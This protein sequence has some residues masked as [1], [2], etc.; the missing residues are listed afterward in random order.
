[1]RLLVLSVTLALAATAALAGTPVSISGIYPGL[2][3]FN[4]NGECGVGAVVPWAGRLWWFTYPPH[5]RTGSDDGLYSTD[6]SMT[7]TRHPE[8][9]GGTH[10]A[11]L[12]HRE[13][14][15]LFLGPYAIDDRGRVRV[16]DVKAIPGRY[17]AWAR[18]LTD[19]ANKLLLFDMEGPVWEVDVR[20]LAGTKLFDK[21]VPGWHGKGAY[22]AQ[23]RYVVANNGESAA[24]RR[25]KDGEFLCK[26]P[27]KSAEDAGVLAEWDGREWRIVERRQFTE[28][29][30]PGGIEGSPDDTAPL[31]A[32]GWDRRSVIL[33]LLDGGAWST[34]RL[35]KGSHTFDPSHGWFTEW[36]R[37][38]SIGAAR[39]MMVMHGQMFDFPGGFRTGTTGGLRPIATHLRYIPDFCEWNGRLVLASDDCSVMQNPL[40]GKSQSNL[41]FGKPEDLAT[42]G[43]PQGWGGVWLGDPVKG[44]V[45]SDPFL[46]AGYT[47]RMVHL[48]HNAGSPVTFRFEIDRGGTGAWEPLTQVTVGAAGYAYSVFP[49]DA[50]GEWIRVTADRDLPAGSAYFHYLPTRAHAAAAAD[51]LFAGLA[52]VAKAGADAAWTGVLLRPGDSVL[53]VVA[54]PAR[55]AGTGGA[56]RYYEVD[57]S[58][59]FRRVDAADTAAAVEKTNAIAVDFAVDRASV[60]VTDPAGVRYRIPR[61]SAD[62]DRFA[63]GALRGV[64][65]CVSERYLANFCGIFYEIPRTDTKAAPYFRQMKPVAAHGFA[66]ADFCTWR[67]LMVL[68]GCRADAKPDGHVFA[69]SDG[70]M[71][72]WFGQIDDLWKLGKPVGTGGP[73]KDTAVKA[74]APS[75]PY[76][77]TGYDRKT[78]RLGHTANRPVT[79]RVEIDYSN[80]DF[81]KAYGEFAVKPGETLV[82]EFPADFSA[83]WV[84]VVANA[85]CTATAQLDYR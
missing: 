61:A 2:T 55:S 59:A 64:R 65:E 43:A 82:H 51:G 21:P 54:G 58:M 11:R 68:A 14:K 35:P 70:S 46:F 33:K 3:V 71:A 79:V 41:W 19:P 69:A 16:L 63:P 34:F 72:L 44:G 26:L 38:R 53:H 77:M 25:P 18:H 56:T 9:V 6:G 57:G 30:G 15:Q 20:T 8:S 27:P 83:H 60:I 75:D 28:V 24:G 84:R 62:F 4:T 47:R 66:I 1:M 12:I 17:T 76:L 40:A 42:F 22:T 67:G 36:P 78:L 52:P 23:G 37:I 7:L 74:G 48:A 31:W 13:S 49:A 81:W 5:C 29:T 10:A 80:R 85:D 73:W 32:T 50:P 45:P 39:R